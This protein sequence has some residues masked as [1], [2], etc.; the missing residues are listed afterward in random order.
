MSY[1]FSLIKSTILT[2]ACNRAPY[3]WHNV[4]PAIPIFFAY[5]FYICISSFLHGSVTD[6]GVSPGESTT[7]IGPL[8]DHSFQILPRELHALPALENEDDPLTIGPSLADWAMI[9]PS[10]WATTAMEVPINYCKT[11][12][13][14]RPPRG[15]HCR[16]CDNCIEAQD[17]HCVW[18]NNCVGRRNYRY[19][20]TFVTSGTFLGI[21]LVFASLGHC[22][23]YQSASSTSFG[24]ALNVCRVPF[25][26]FIFGILITPYPAGLMGYH[27]FL[28]G[29]G[30]TTREYLNSHKF[31][32][33]D[34]HRPFDQGS[35]FA[36]WVVVFF[37]PRPPTYLRFHDKHEEGDQRFG[38]RREKIKAQRIP[39]Q[40]HNMEMRIAGHSV[41]SFQEPATR[42]DV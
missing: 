5:N 22:L 25:A 10:G 19:F 42:A 17:H 16:I 41:D 37:R 23:H 35:T 32:K 18:L 36:N 8:A 30:E 40:H 21:F 28:M 14:W 38:S 12:S 31:L 34:R 11:C 24:E 6:P 4:S 39:T 7:F 9:K 20:F 3:L 13:I 1:H 29:Q 33:K 2:I 26:L 15:H 27:L